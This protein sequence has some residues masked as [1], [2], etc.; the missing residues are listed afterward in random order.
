MAKGRVFWKPH[1]QAKILE[2]AGR[3]K[4]ENPKLGWADTVLK[5]QLVLDEDRQKPSVPPP[6][7]HPTFKWFQDGIDEAVR[8]AQMG[9]VNG[10]LYDD[11]KTDVLDADA[12]A[13][14][15]NQD[16]IVDTPSDPVDKEIPEDLT[17]VVS[18]LVQAIKD[19]QP[20][21]SFVQNAVINQLA[22]I[23]DRVMSLEKQFKT[24]LERGFTL[25][26]TPIGT[27]QPL[28]S[29]QLHPVTISST[30]PAPDVVAPQ[31]SF[32]HAPSIPTRKPRIIVLNVDSGNTKHGIRLGASSLVAR[33]E[34]ADTYPTKYPPY[35]EYDYILAYKKTPRTWS[36]GAEIQ[37]GTKRFHAVPGGAVQVVEFIKKLPPIQEKTKD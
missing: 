13:G 22:D 2:E 29:S 23:R 27:V 33:I 21:D 15:D 24:F 6:M 37:Y 7:T 35:Q 20:P 10:D 3:I 19:F 14:D 28:T 34:F 18:T 30:T 26:L 25:S 17:S 1:E 32:H 36:D 11:L 12:N 4:A 9:S 8:K 5:A 31:A 16:A